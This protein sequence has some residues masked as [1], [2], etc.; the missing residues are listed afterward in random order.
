MAE[1]RTSQH[2][3]SQTDTYFRALA[4]ASPDAVSVL[5]CDGVVCFAN[6]RAL[7]ATDRAAL[8]GRPWLELWEEEHRGE[9]GRLLEVA[10]R[11]GTARTRTF[12]ATPEGGTQ[13]WDTI[14]TPVNRDG[15]VVSL[16]ATSR[17][18][19]AQIEAQSILDTVIE[20]VPAVLFAKDARDGRFVLL[21]RAA[22]EYFGMSKDE[23][24]GRTSAELF[25][26][27]R[28][29]IMAE[30]DGD[31]VRTGRVYVREQSIDIPF[32][33]ERVFKT[34]V[35]ATFGDEGARHLIGV[36]EDV[37]DERAAAEALKAAA[38]RAETAN[39]SKS[40]FLANMSH[41]IRTPL[42][43]VVAV[44]DVLARTRL[45]ERQREMVEIVR[46]SGVTLERLLSDVLDLARIE[47][48]AIEIQREPFH[49]GDAVRGVAGLMAMRAQEKGVAL[50]VQI[51]PEAEVRVIGDIVRFKQILTNLTSNA[52]KFTERGE[53][54]IGVELQEDQEDGPTFR[55][56]VRD[57]GVGFDPAG[58]DRV[59]GRFQQADGSITRRFGG[60]G[61]GLAISRQLAELMG[62]TLECDSELGRGSI[63]W[64][65][66]PLPAAE[67]EV[68]P[69]GAVE[70]TYGEATVSDR[71][72]RILVADDHPTNRKIVELILAP[73]GVELVSV[74]DGSQ[75]LEAFGAGTFDAVLM[76]MQMPVMDGLTATREI[77]R[78]E[79]ESG[80]RPTPVFML[81]ANALPEHLEASRA[82]GADRHMTKPITAEKLVQALLELADSVARAA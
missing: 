17:D 44:A 1:Q 59:F 2:D 47:S 79:R 46:S 34:R 14:V 18:V 73:L 20:Y 26:P 64:V 15:Q 28:A 43:G 6:T 41:E 9:I 8:L 58:K 54:R 50:N 68:G 61:L 71:A 30:A 11:G 16:I 39:R 66:L 4:A 3:L 65:T 52:V 32:E 78:R 40:E 55:L 77:R 35:M 24:L 81:T 12:R 13:W 57:T 69:A 60:T 70:A 38:E 31:V 80:L 25:S 63:F 37:T 33:G 36:A 22:E 51:A 62:G 49:L 19:T 42:N 23:M 5:D 45:D 67:A 74:E 21:N 7:E 75:A 82:A 72:M 48:G 56:W 10:R 76:D 27:E 29:A 53:V